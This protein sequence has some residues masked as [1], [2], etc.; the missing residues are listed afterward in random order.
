MK[1]ALVLLALALLMAFYLG[2]GALAFNSPISPLYSPDPTR[3]IRET[4]WIAPTP[5]PDFDR[6]GNLLPDDPTETPTPSPA[7]TAT[8][9][10]VCPEAMETPAI[11]EPVFVP[12]FVPISPVF[13]S[14]IATPIPE[15][16]CVAPGMHGQIVC[17]EVQ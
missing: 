4:G 1:C 10:V 5:M 6:D 16:I 14:P 3:I 12:V 2:G 7:P 15:F 11:P 17:Y 9:C 13:H 8:P